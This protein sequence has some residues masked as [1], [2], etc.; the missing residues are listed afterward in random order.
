MTVSP[1][2]LVA[3]QQA[4]AVY[5]PEQP[6]YESACLPWNCAVAQ[7]PVAVA[8][9]NSV[10]ELVTIVRAAVESGLRIAPQ[11]TGHAA[12]ALAPTAL[13][14]ALLL[15]LHEL[16]GVSV[17]PQAQTARIVGGTLWRDVLAA[18]APHGLTA[19]HGSA[20]DVSAIGF[21]LG[22]GLSF[23]GRSHGLGSSSVRAVEIV[24]AD[25]AV[26]RASATEHPELFWAVRGGGG[27]FGVVVAVEI[28]LLP[29]PDVVAGMLLWDLARAP[30]VLTVWASWTATAP[31]AASTS[32]RMMRFPPLPELPDFL[33]GRQVVVID[34]AVLGSD[35]EAARVLAPL[36]SLAPEIDTFTRI[37][38]EGLLT[39]HMDPPGPTPTV[40]DHALLT[41]LPADA[42]A[43]LLAA[44]GP[45][46]QTSIMFAELRHLGGAFDRP[47]DAALERIRASYV[48]FAAA[49]AAT[50][51]MA[52]M[53]VAE[54]SGVVSALRPWAGCTELANFKDRPGQA[55]LCFDADSWARLLSVRAQYDPR[56]VWVAAHPV[57]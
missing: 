12:A 11:S 32:L 25:G 55:D 41:S 35:D 56:G 3:L 39:V 50:P 43:A 1:I 47:I 28:D 52:T 24:D 38:S 16:T 13:D 51:E 49:V 10:P 57:A 9:P 27:S 48:L 36:R 15:R 37:P 45:A 8:V 33:R 4:G 17:D 54:T 19:L 14:G 42:V 34:G 30:E 40:T 26:L 18:C 44:A 21:L 6:E 53:G 7:R 46:A 20:G 29:L 2:D 22:G 5:L 31:E 23:Y